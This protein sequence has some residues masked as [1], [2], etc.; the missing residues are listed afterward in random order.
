[1][2][3]IVLLIS[4]ALILAGCAYGYEAPDGTVDKPKKIPDDQGISIIELG[5]KE[6]PAQTDQPNYEY[7]Y[8]TPPTVNDPEYQ[9]YLE[10]KEWQEFKKYQEWKREQGAAAS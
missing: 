8:E 3:N 9:E 5:N 10:W 1:M 4:I 2:K 7:Q 6:K